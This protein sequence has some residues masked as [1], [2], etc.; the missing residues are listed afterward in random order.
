[1]ISHWEKAEDAEFNYQQMFYDEE[2]GEEDDTGSEGDEEYAGGINAMDAV[3]DFVVSR[4]DGAGVQQMAEAIGESF[5]ITMGAVAV[6]L[7]LRVMQL[8]P[9]GAR[10]RMTPEGWPCLKG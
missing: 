4:Q 10:V 8:D 2:S 6:W 7:E 5:E 3:Y 1:M 9:G